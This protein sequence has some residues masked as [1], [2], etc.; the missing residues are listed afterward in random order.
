MECILIDRNRKQLR[1]STRNSYTHYK[2]VEFGLKLP[3]ILTFI[4]RLSRQ[5]NHYA[6]E[7]KTIQRAWDEFMGVSLTKWM[8]EM[9]ERMNK[10]IDRLMEERKKEYLYN[11]RY[12]NRY[13][14]K[15]IQE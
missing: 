2:L 14:S 12:N 13:F 1:I 4:M 7:D 8:N 6:S 10:L 15:L 3:L 5:K 9:N 11:N